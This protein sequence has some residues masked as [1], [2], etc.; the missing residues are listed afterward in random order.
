MLN[1]FQ[2][3]S[4]C[5]TLNSTIVTF[6]SAEEHAFVTHEVLS[7]AYG[8]VWIGLT[9]D[10]SNKGLWRWE[11]GTHLSF[12]QWESTQPDYINDDCAQMMFG[13]HYKIYW[14]HEWHG[15]NCERLTRDPGFICERRANI[16]E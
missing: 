6:N 15:T 12:T 11:D 1:F 4:Y 2:A 10:P 3:K 13:L 7:E 9:R 16:N 14:Y 5:Q 8:G